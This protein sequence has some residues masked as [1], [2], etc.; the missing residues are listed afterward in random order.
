MAWPYLLRPVA[1][2]AELAGSTATD[3]TSVYGYPGPLAWGCEPGDAFLDQAWR[4]IVGLWREQGAV[5]AFT[6]FHPLLGNAALADGF[7]SPADPSGG[8]VGVV[9]VGPTV[10]VDLTAGLDGI[11]EGYGRDLRREIAVAQR[12]GLATEHDEAW[13]ELATFTR[14]YRETMIRNRASEYY[15]FGEDDFRRLR[16]A[17]GDRLHLLVTR[18]AGAVSAAGLF[19]EYRGIVEWYL[20]GTSDAYRKVSP[21]KVLIDDAIVWAR[22]RGDTVLHFGGGRGGREDSLLWF[23]SRFSR[24]RHDFHIGRWILDPAAYSELLTARRADVAGQG[25][26]DPGFFPGYRAPLRRDLVPQ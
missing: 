15:F 16:A 12:A 13:R 2:V 11:R 8:S 20:V 14:L 26:L 1:A 4:S 6:R 21:S 17:L 9:P 25:Q 5:S 10:S 7:Q 23:K 3:V 24:R 19:T 22:Q 18:A